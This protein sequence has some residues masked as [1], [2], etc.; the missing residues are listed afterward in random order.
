MVIGRA[1]ACWKM[2]TTP[3]EIS[4]MDVHMVF[5]EDSKFRYTHGPAPDVTPLEDA[6]MNAAE[7]NI[8]MA[9]KVFKIACSRPGS[10]R[11]GV[12]LAIV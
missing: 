4:M 9:A 5:F 1:E 11:L 12:R 8:S 6:E 10:R 3:Q 2:L 7:T